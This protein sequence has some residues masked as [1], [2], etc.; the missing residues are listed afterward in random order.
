MKSINTHQKLAKLEKN[1]G[2]TDTVDLIQTAL[3]ILIERKATLGKLLLAEDLEG[4]S[5]CAHKTLGS[6]RLYGT[7]Q[8]ESLLTQ[9]KELNPDQVDLIDFQGQIS[10]EFSMVID[11][12]IKWLK[13]NE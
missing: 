10:E 7:D 4:A 12:C 1:I 13:N 6:V 3:P 8:L 9:V 2:I 5:A 11:D